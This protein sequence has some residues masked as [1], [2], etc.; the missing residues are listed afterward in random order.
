MPDNDAPTGFRLDVDA[1]FLTFETLLA[2]GTAP[3]ALLS[4]AVGFQT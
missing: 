4:S 3:N 1:L 2:F